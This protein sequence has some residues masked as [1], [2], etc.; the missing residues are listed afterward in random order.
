MQKF[1]FIFI[2]LCYINTEDLKE[3]LKS[4]QSIKGTY[5][6]I[7]VNSY[8]DNIT[9]NE[10][11]KIALENKC[12]FINVPNKGY[13]FGNNQGIKFANEHYAYDF[14]VI[15]N[16]DIEFINFDV[17]LIDGCQ[18]MLIGP[19]IK[20]KNGKYQNPYKPVKMWLIDGMEYYGIKYDFYPFWFLGAAF[21]KLLRELIVRIA[22][23]FG[24]MKVDSLHGSCMLIGSAAMKKLSNEELYDV[25]MFLFSEEDEVA[26]KAKLNKVPL[27]YI[28]K[29]N[30][31]HKEDGSTSLIENKISGYTKAS[32][33][34]CYKKW[35]RW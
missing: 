30:I 25:N 35:N 12:D 8:Y 24:E 32:Y 26:Y 19:Q 14:L 18:N 6:I 22:A 23:V 5:K 34:Y 1:N 15:A 4:V 17:S 29:L 20:T 7:V 28:P 2:V 3:F 11:E 21:N 16:P 27:L 33:I 10:F 9:M 31:L 13:G